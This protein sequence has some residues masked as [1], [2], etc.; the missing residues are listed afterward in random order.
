MKIA[1]ISTIDSRDRHAISGAGYSIPVS[2]QSQGA[3]VQPIHSLKGKY[4]WDEILKCRFYR[5]VLNQGYL[6]DKTASH[7]KSMGQSASAALSQIDY[8]AILSPVYEP[9]AYLNVSAPKYLWSDHTFE[10]HL[11]RYPEYTGLC[12]E[13]VRQA[14][15]MQRKVIKDCKSLFFSSE[16]TAQT[17]VEFYGADPKKVHVIP[18]GP[19]ID[20]NFT[21]DD[22]YKRIEGDF[23]NECRLIM[24]SSHWERKRCDFGISV[25]KLLNDRGIPSRIKIV[26]AKPSHANSLPNYV[27]LLGFIKRYSEEGMKYSIDLYKESFFHLF[28]SREEAYGAVVCEASAVGL[29]T[30]GSNIG[31][32]ATTVHEGLNGHLINRNGSAEEYAAII[33]KYWNAK[34]DYK[35][36]C[37]SSFNEYEKRLNWKTSAEKVLEVMKKDRET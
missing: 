9:L 10:N 34:E 21:V 11:N 33:E 35:K 14:H 7:L 20:G 26:G 3:M 2:L 25:C 32:I 12:Q 6:I 17:A 15:R 8:N 37:I 28:P 23:W 13:T 31:G 24:V 22:V 4:R 19:N 30:I 27:E 5:K 29:P 18:F 1:Y 16:L 36:L